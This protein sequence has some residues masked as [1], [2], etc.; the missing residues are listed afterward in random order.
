MKKVLTLAIVTFCLATLLFGGSWET[1]KVASTDMMVTKAS[2]IDANTGW[3]V[4]STTYPT[5]QMGRVQKTINGGLDWTTVREPD[6][7]DY[8]WN[9]ME[10]IDANVGYA[11][12]EGGIIYKTTNGGADWTMIG[13][14]NCHIAQHR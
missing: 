13:D 5:H 14:T 10:F 8:A 11:C 2:F 1:V 9:D 4:Y 12:G 7:T 3:I 6:V